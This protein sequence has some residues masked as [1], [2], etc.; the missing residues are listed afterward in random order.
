[1]PA[2]GSRVAYGYYIS[3]GLFQHTF[4][5]F[6]TIGAV[7]LANTIGKEVAM[8]KQQVLIID[9]GIDIKEIAVT[10]TCC[11]TGPAPLKK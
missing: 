1:M 3:V 6:G 11:K 9:K 5:R 10:V 2:A 8:E 7:S 4:P